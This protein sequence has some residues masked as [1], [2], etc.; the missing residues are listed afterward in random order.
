MLFFQLL[1]ASISHLVVCKSK[2]INRLVSANP[3]KENEIRQLSLQNL[4]DQVFFLQRRIRSYYCLVIIRSARPGPTT[5][6]SSV[7]QDSNRK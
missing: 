5:E 7:T 1:I 3:E 4:N 6:A 2:M